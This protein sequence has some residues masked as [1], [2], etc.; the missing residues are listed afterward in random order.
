MKITNY[1]FFGAL[2]SKKRFSIIKALM[3]EEL[4]V[5]EIC[6]KLRC[7]QTNVSHQLKILQNY[8]IVFSKR[9]GKKKIYSINE[10]LRPIIRQAQRFVRKNCINKA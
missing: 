10:E 3:K 2:S 7:E 5:K 8:G 9:A 1:G 4:S 6:T